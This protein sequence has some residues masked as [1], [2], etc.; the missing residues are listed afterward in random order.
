MIQNRRP[1]PAPKSRAF[2]PVLKVTQHG[3]A[4]VILHLYK[5]AAA[6]ADA[7]RA[8]GAPITIAVRGRLSDIT[9]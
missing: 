8:I 9:G 5:C 7:A 4:Q 3:V 1:F 6:L 2:S